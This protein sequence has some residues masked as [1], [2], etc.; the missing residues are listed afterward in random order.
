MATSASFVGNYAILPTLLSASDIAK[1]IKRNPKSVTSFLTR[2]AE[3][4]PGCRAELEVKRVNEPQYLY[5]TAEV[6]P[7]IQEWLKDGADG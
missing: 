3:K 6:W 4:Y 5:R 7:A 2:F 1:F